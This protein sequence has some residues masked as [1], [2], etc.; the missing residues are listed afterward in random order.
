MMWA[1]PSLV[2]AQA[3]QPE[4]FIDYKNKAILVNIALSDT[5]DFEIGYTAFSLRM[6]SYNLSSMKTTDI[7]N[8]FYEYRSDGLF[9]AFPINAFIKKQNKAKFPPDQYRYA[10][11]F[12]K[13]DELI[14]SFN[15]EAVDKMILEW[16]R[17]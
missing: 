15:S 17:E 8:H 3:S 9:V 12:R 2:I 6:V 13:D 16:L 7:Y 4:Y 10:M 11:I 14:E 5:L 1:V